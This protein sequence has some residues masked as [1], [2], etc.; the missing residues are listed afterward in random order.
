MLYQL[1]KKINGSFGFADDRSLSLF[2]SMRI[3]LSAVFVSTIC[4]ACSDNPTSAPV[5]AP[6][7]SD[8]L[9]KLVMAGHDE[10]MAK[11]GRLKKY[12]ARL[13]YLVDS[14]SAS[15]S[16]DP[17]MIRRMK[18]TRDSLNAANDAM[19]VWMEQFSADTLQDDA[20]KRAKYLEA[21]KASVTLVRD[22]IFNSLALY[23][24][25]KIK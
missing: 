9:F 1:A 24:S 20:A 18:Q 3:F 17:Q 2:L 11:V 13:Q 16:I 19:F 21:Q 14:L 12:S 10:G 15:K 4:Y 25:L 23:D 6:N 8:S 22:R 7:Q 5:A